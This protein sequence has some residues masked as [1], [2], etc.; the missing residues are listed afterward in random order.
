MPGTRSSAPFF[1]LA[2]LGHVFSHRCMER[3]VSQRRSV[4]RPPQNKHPGTAF[5]VTTQIWVRKPPSTYP[6]SLYP[7]LQNSAASIP[8]SIHAYPHLLRQSIIPLE[9]LLP[10]NS[11]WLSN[12]ADSLV[13]IIMVFLVLLRWCFIYLRWPYPTLFFH[14]S[15]YPFCVP[16]HVTIFFKFVC[17][18]VQQKCLE[19]AAQPEDETWS[20]YREIPHGPS[21]TWE[22]LWEQNWLWPGPVHPLEVLIPVGFSCKQ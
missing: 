4:K 17:L 9:Y 18:T 21:S 3:T 16:F 22:L 12:W 7:H 13:R 1:P 10:S 20:N 19:L 5:S 11:V 8:P 2:C 14:K 6:H 15:Y